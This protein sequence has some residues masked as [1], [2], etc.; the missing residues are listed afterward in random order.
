MVQNIYLAF[1]VWD[2]DLQHDFWYSMWNLNL[3]LHDC[4]RQCIRSSTI[5]SF[6]IYNRNNITEKAKT[7]YDLQG[8]KKK[9]LCHD[10][11][12]GPII[13]SNHKKD[14]P[15]PFSFIISVFNF[16]YFSPIFFYFLHFETELPLTIFFF[17]AQKRQQIVKYKQQ[18]LQTEG[19]KHLLP[20]LI[21]SSYV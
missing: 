4:V 17:W 9:P 15:F 13:F 19:V 5:F 18:K 14:V 1:E 10:S 3:Y 11:W 8:K 7:W 6:I 16:P 12:P 21:G 2:C 20:H